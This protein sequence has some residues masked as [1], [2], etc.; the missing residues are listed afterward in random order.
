MWHVTFLMLVLGSGFWV[1]TMWQVT[2]DT[3]HYWCMRHVTLLQT[4]DVECFVFFP[5][6]GLLDDLILTNIHS[7]RPCRGV[8][9]LQKMYI[10]WNSGPTPVEIYSH[11]L[12]L[13]GHMWSVKLGLFFVDPSWQFL[14]IWVPWM[15][16]RSFAQGN[17]TRLRRSRMFWCLE[18]QCSA[19]E[20][21]NAQKTT[22]KKGRYMEGI[23]ECLFHLG[24]AT[25]YA[26]TIVLLE[27]W[28]DVVVHLN[29]FDF[30]KW[31]LDRSTSKM[32]QF[33][34]RSFTF[35]HCFTCSNSCLIQHAQ[36]F[37]NFSIFWFFGNNV[38]LFYLTI[39]RQNVCRLLCRG[40]VYCNARRMMGRDEIEKSCNEIPLLG[41]TRC[42]E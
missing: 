18:P 5:L 34:E 6:R 38:F 31:Y 25:Y 7:T 26:S 28:F 3:W 13:K 2:C 30:W 10:C 16:A 33:C 21:N 20:Q 27:V 39:G 24:V 36:F 42:I 9:E 1:G 37:W 12:Y 8:S 4:S 15:E 19:V 40:P 32:F 41:W 11:V 35:L 17:S 22:Y 23:L 14:V 29:R